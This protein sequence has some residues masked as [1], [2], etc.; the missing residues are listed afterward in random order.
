[1]ERQKALGLVCEKVKT[2]NL[3]KHLLATE[4][5]MRAL[6]NRFGEDVEIWG[7]AGL[8]HAGS[9]ISFGVKAS[10]AFGTGRAHGTRNH[11]NGL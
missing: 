11:F 7:I 10:T 1:M 2:K 8:V 3:I 6:A 9:L 4:V 5:V